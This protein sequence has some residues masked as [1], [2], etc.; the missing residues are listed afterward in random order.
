M[1]DG[2]EFWLTVAVMLVVVAFFVAAVIWWS[3]RSGWR[4]PDK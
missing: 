1:S 2:A 3:E 4:P